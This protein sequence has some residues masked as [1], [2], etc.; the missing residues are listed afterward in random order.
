[1][2]THGNTL[3]AAGVIW[4]GFIGS[5]GDVSADEPPADSKLILSAPL[6]HSD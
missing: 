2:H 4:L 1:M 3:F 5:F 6:T